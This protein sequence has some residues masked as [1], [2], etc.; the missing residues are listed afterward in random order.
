MRVDTIVRDVR[1][2]VEQI[3]RVLAHG[4]TAEENFGGQGTVGQVLTSTGPNTPP[5][6]Q[7]ATSVP[8]SAADLAAL[9]ARVE[10]LEQAAIVTAPS[11]GTWAWDGTVEV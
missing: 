9:V 6:W 2:A 8:A 10:A 7:S 5:T 1:R 3:V 4:L 11:T